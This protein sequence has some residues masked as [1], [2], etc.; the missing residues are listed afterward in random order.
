MPR[1]VNLNSNLNNNNAAA[2]ETKL[3]QRK[4]KKQLIPPG[5]NSNV[6]RVNGVNNGTG[7]VNGAN[8]N[9][10]RVNG[11]NGANSNV[12]RVNGVN[13]G[14]VRVNGAN[15]TTRRN[16][17]FNQQSQIPMN[18]SILNNPNGQSN[19]T[20]NLNNSRNK[21][22]SAQVPVKELLYFNGN[23]IYPC[24]KGENDVV[25]ELM[26]FQIQVHNICNKYKWEIQEVSNRGRKY[27]LTNGVEIHYINFSGNP[28]VRKA[29]NEI[30]NDQNNSNNYSQ[31]QALISSTNNKYT[32][33]NTGVDDNS[34]DYQ[35]AIRFVGL[36]AILDDDNKNDAESD[37]DILIDIDKNT[38]P[39]VFN[40][41]N[42]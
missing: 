21:N 6:G 2:L 14:N 35:I 20:L 4:M 1:Q 3:L 11:V 42:K 16:N 17:Q 41:S 28:N 33:K 29:Y 36:N 24:E 31:I 37:I 15:N 18:G 10:G 8:S 26:H 27:K 23:Y 34:F 19:L 22:N 32:N 39:T 9:V 25:Q 40:F 7:R 38:S 30:I 12:G 5:A 13:N